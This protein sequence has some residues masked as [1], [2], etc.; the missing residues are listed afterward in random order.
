[1]TFL[2]AVIRISRRMWAADPAIRSPRERMALA[3]ACMLNGSV[4]AAQGRGFT[5]PGLKASS[6]ARTLHTH[7]VLDEI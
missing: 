1:M 2:R 3:R 6:L 7:G 4:Q 5:L